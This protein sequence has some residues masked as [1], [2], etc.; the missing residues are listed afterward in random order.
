MKA[1][2]T[3]RHILGALVVAL[4]LHTG[5]V[6]A[7]SPSRVVAFGDSNVDTGNLF[8]ALGQPGGRNSNGS[9]V[10]EYVSQALSVPL[11]NFAWSG[12]TSGATNVVGA[13][14]PA[15]LNTGLLSQ[16]GTF[17]S[18]L[19]GG[20]ADAHG[21]YIVWAGS[22]DLFGI[23][24]TDPA[25]VTAR[26][27]GVVANLTSAVTTLDGLGAR[28]IL[29]ATRTPRPELASAN[30][31]AGVQMNDAIRSLIPTV[32]A[33]L[34]ARVELFDAYALIENMVLNP[35]TYGFTENLALCSSSA[36]CANDLN[37]ARGWINWDGAHKTTRVHELLGDAML[38]QAVPEPASMSLMALGMLALLG[39]ARRQARRLPALRSA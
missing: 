10:T 25:V 12:A 36:A 29:V 11:Q 13:S 6:Q 19:G 2:M 39:V 18:G 37:V 24:V 5:L 27:D 3:I 30:N 22:N 33:S 7:A 38:A 23:D 31:L 32:D 4:W 28:H 16:L 35:A 8:G 1:F 15:L 14:I 26:V 9:L 17:S 20:A 34:V 21:L